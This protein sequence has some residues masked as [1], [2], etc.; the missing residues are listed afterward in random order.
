VEVSC[1]G[2]RFYAPFRDSMGCLHMSMC[3]WR[4]AAALQQRH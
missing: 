1:N 2:R 4:D 3:E